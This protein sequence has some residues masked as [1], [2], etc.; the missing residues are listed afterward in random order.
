MKKVT[1]V[2]L[3]AV[4]LTGFARANNLFT[5]PSFEN[6]DPDPF[7][8]FLDWTS[9]AASGSVKAVTPGLASAH[10]V[11]LS[12]DITQD[13]LEHHYSQ[14]SQFV[15]ET[16]V[17]NIAVFGIWAKTTDSHGGQKLS[18]TLKDGP[19]FAMSSILVDTQERWAFF[20]LK[21]LLKNHTKLNWVEFSVEGD[22]MIDNHKLYLDNAV[23]STVPEPATMLVLAPAAVAVMRRRRKNA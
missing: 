6:L 11:Q 13:P 17:S 14:V 12:T 16:L 19:A 9:S 1:Y 2:V 23:L 4:S 21:P 15:P 22:N 18:V 5:D 7:G 8:V 20:D 3:A 10:A